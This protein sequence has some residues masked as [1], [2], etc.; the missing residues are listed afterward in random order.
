MKALLNKSVFLALFLISSQTLGQLTVSSIAEIGLPSIVVIE[1]SAGTGSGVVIDNSGIVATN[2]HVID[3]S[4]SL[5]VRLSQGDVYSDVSIIDYDS[6]RD[7]AI[8]KI[9]G[10]DLP[11]VPLGNSNAVSVGDDVIIMGAPE[12]F[13]QSVSRGIISA[14]RDSGDGYSL[15]QTDAAISSGSSGGGMFDMSGNLIGITVAYIEDAQNINFVIPINYFRGLFSTEP[16]YTL[17]EFLELEG[18]NTSVKLASSFTTLE[19]LV[20]SLSSEYELAF[21]WNEDIESWVLFEDDNYVSISQV[22]GIINSFVY[23]SVHQREF[24][25]EEYRKI[26]NESYLSNFGKLVIDRDGDLIALNETPLA[27]YTLDHLAS[28]LTSLLLLNESVTELLAESN[29]PQSKPEQIKPN[30]TINRTVRR[31]SNRSFLNDKFSIRV[32]S[33]DWSADPDDESDE[34][35]EQFV[36]TGSDSDTWFQVIAENVELSLQVMPDII[37]ANASDLD[38]NATITESGSRTVNGEITFWARMEVESSGIPFSFYYHIYTGD[39]GTVQIIGW[40]YKTLFEEKAPLFEE[41][42]SSFLVN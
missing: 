34:V 7:I 28:V 33:N 17:T 39:E 21:E 23:S 35:D 24:S 13:E 42:F 5:S 15:F 6:N 12:G 1:G 14:M 41:I 36:Y 29:I 19:E 31:Y 11:T 30:L 38:P 16:K 18:N 10:F 26:L 4:E 32:N 2:F 20:S 3:G 27:N 37:L 40:T 25:S 9:K 22:G 8:L